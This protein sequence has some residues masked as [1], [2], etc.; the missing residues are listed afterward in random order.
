M[1][2]KALEWFA[3]ALVIIGALALT[4]EAYLI[5]KIA[6]FVGA[7]AWLVLGYL[8]RKNSMIVVNMFLAGVFIYDQFQ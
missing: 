3:T 2:T 1:M 5:S 6:Y 8:W 7:V 4:Q